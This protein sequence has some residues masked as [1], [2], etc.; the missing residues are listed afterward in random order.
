M[1]VS[2]ITVTY[3]SEKTIK[4]TLD[5]VAVQ[6]YNNIEYIIVDGASS[7]ATLQII[8]NSSALVTKCI[9][10]RDK[11]IY[12][13]LN[14]GVHL[15]TG[16]IIGF[17][18][19]DDILARP[20]IIETIVIEF[21]KTKADIVYGDLVFVDRSDVNNIVRYWHSGSFR[22][23]K[24]SLGWAPPHPSFYMK[25]SLYKEDGFFDLT[26]KIAADYDQMIR[27]L[28]RERIKVIYLPQ[29]FV[30]M[31]LGG[32]STKLDN[33]VASTKEI[34]SIMKKHHI[35]WYVAIITRKFSKLAQLF[36]K[37]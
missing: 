16:D 21:Q 36:R 33:T 25:R 28:K 8:N 11:G 22:K 31:R 30:K 34:I 26:F 32:E 2:I 1:K 13:A 27:V 5:S 9:S 37:S 24:I 7:D 20:D 18:H 12:D 35:N 14:K 19:S 23:S 3:N 4:D 29:V 6:T 15:A 10:E 17:I